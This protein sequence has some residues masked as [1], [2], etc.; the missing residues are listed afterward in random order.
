MQ[1]V[2]KRLPDIE[3]QVIEYRMG[4]VDGHPRNLTETARQLRLT[5]HEAK[6]IEA[7]AFERI[8]EVVPLGQLQKLLQQ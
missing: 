3:R 2:L 8:R 5:T 6:E 4:L 7:R 1:R